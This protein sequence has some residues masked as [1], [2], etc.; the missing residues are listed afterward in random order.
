MEE[1]KKKSWRAERQAELTKLCEDPTFA[2]GR[3]I[4]GQRVYEVP[5]KVT[6][7]RLFNYVEACEAVTDEEKTRVKELR[8]RFKKEMQIQWI[9][10]LLLLLLGFVLV[11]MY[12]MQYGVVV[13]GIGSLV[14]WIPLKANLLIQFTNITMI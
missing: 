8:R 1:M 9:S 3:L 13:L 4:L 5:A 14:T 7:N 2:L 12:G 11:A 6:L 10:H